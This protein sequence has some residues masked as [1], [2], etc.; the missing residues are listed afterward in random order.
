MRRRGTQKQSALV[1]VYLA[2]CRPLNFSPYKHQLLY[3]RIMNKKRNYISHK[4]F[5]GFG[6]K[7][8]F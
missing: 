3:E 2:A 5:F 4:Y 7:N 8:R 1:T 6:S